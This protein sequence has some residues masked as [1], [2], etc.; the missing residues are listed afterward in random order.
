MEEARGI[1]DRGAPVDRV[2]TLASLPLVRIQLLFP[3]KTTGSHIPSR[4]EGFID[5]VIETLHDAMR[6]LGQTQPGLHN[7]PNNNTACD[8]AALRFFSPANQRMLGP[9]NRDQQVANDNPRPGRT[10]IRRRLPFVS[11][12]VRKDTSPRTMLEGPAWSPLVTPPRALSKSSETKTPAWSPLIA[13]PRTLSTSSEAKPPASGQQVALRRSST[14][15]SEGK[16]PV[17]NHRVTLPKP[18]PRTAS[19]HNILS[20]GKHVVTWRKEPSTAPKDKYDSSS[21]GK[22]Q[23]RLCKEALLGAAQKWRFAPRSERLKYLLCFDDNDDPAAHKPPDPAEIRKDRMR[24]EHYAFR[25]IEMDTH[26]MKMYGTWDLH[27]LDLLKFWVNMN[28]HRMRSN[29]LWPPGYQPQGLWQEFMGPFQNTEQLM[30][31]V[32]GGDRGSPG[33]DMKFID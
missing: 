27:D 28:Q 15:V 1:L 6:M 11:P 17:R 18:R 8:Q 19:E 14:T 13:L 9:L 24:Y 5:S 30:V 25:S 32:R 29:S 10:R 4:P 23:R 33:S 12:D 16:P 31:S 22:S 3:S 21:N 7:E 26:P 20:A 2:R